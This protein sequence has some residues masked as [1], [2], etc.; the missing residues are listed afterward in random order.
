MPYCMIRSF[1]QCGQCVYVHGWTKTRDVALRSGDSLLPP[2][3]FLVRP[4]Y[5]SWYLV[6]TRILPERAIVPRPLPAYPA[7]SA[8]TR[9]QPVR[10]RQTAC[11][12]YR[13]YHTRSYRVTPQFLPSTLRYLA[14]DIFA[15]VLRLAHTYRS[16]GCRFVKFTLLDLRSSHAAG[17]GVSPPTIVVPFMDK[18]HFT[19]RPSC[20]ALRTC[21]LRHAFCALLTFLVG[22]VT[23]GTFV[24][25][26]RF[27]PL[28]ATAPVCSLCIV[29]CRF[30]SMPQPTILLLYLGPSTSVNL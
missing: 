1:C 2:R 3:A 27:F 11:W 24:S 22:S 10:Y 18:R 30:R 20:H 15:D 23:T 13:A 16:V 29:P 9:F 25:S 5:G 19:C 17:A 12:L 14:L 21:G 7:R 28:S 26:P 8:V 4:R 6:S